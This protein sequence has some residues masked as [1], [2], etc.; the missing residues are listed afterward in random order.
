MKN[1]FVIFV[2]FICLPVIAQ[3]DLELKTVKTF[4]GKGALSSGYDISIYFANSENGFQITGNHTRVY[5]TYSWQVS[6]F[7]VLATG[8][9]FKNAPWAGP[10]IIFSPVEFISTVHWY[11]M[12]A[13]TP[14][15]PDWKIN[16]LVQ[17]N[18]VTIKFKNLSVTYALSK[19]LN[20]PVDQ[21]P[22]VVYTGQLNSSW[23]YTV[24]VDYTVNGQ[25]PL[26]QLGVKHMF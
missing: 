22:G 2:F 26:F 6:Y 14:E 8:G 24:G 3:D 10:Q 1:L 12:S 13:G 21:L 4:I 18:A 11:G 19:F 7:T 9:F 20:D 23:N 15:N 25:E 5:A 17:Y 16:M